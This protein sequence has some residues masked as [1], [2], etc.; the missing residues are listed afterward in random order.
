VQDGAPVALEGHLERLRDSLARVYG[1]DLGPGLGP[2]LERTVAATR[3]QRTRMRIAAAADGAI[4][5]SAIPAPLASERV[6]V[7]APFVLP[8]GLGAHKWSDRGLLE[9]LSRERPD[10]VPLLI[11]SDGT[12]LEAAHA[13][14]WI[15]EDGSWITPPADGRILAGVT[16]ADR[17][18]A[19]PSA[20]EEP[21]SLERLAHA[22]SVF[23]TSSIAGCRAA[24]LRGGDVPVGEP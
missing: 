10:T 24:A 6:V 22:P 14:V 4:T 5:V 21:I 17:L 19:D 1:H 3:G 12:V 18:A 2:E 16:R 7:L 8:G 13:N 15:V 23:L 11:D 9:A 20:A